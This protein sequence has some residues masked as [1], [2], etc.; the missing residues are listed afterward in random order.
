MKTMSATIISL[1]ITA[2]Y[3]LASGNG[4]SGEE[5]GFMAT[6]FIGFGVLILVF[7]TIPAILMFTGLIKGFLSLADKKTTEANASGTGKV[8]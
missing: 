1:L 4:S 8:S 5:L 7:Q 3:A 2:T 6:L